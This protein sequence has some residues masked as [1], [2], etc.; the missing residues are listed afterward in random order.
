MLFRSEYIVDEN[1]VIDYTKV[2]LGPL[3]KGDILITSASHIPFW[4][5]GH[6]ALLVDAKQQI[7]LE[8]IV[9][10]ENSSYQSLRKWKRYPNFIVL[11]LKDST[12]KERS[13]IAE[14]AIQYL[15]DIPYH[16]LVGILTPKEKAAQEIDGTHCSHLIWEAYYLNG[17]DIDSNGGKIVSPEDIVNSNLLEVVQIY[18]LDPNDYLSQL[19]K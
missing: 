19:I 12:L 2:K 14:T 6:A 9:I 4:R 8:A 18:G 11:R 1:G 7:T 3:Q 15:N 16:L 13:Q 17:Y 5:N 10:G